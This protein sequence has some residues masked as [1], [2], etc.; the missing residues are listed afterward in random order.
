M[1][2]NAGPNPYRMRHATWEPGRVASPSTKNTSYPVR[3]QNR[4][5][6]SNTVIKLA[7][8]SGFST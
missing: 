4:A 6:L 8:W 2:H 3:R 5:S 1:S 7:N